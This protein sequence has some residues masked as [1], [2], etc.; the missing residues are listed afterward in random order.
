M[1]I[2]R[3]ASSDRLD[4]GRDG[5]CVSPAGNRGCAPSRGLRMTLPVPP[6][7]F[8][9]ID[10]PCGLSL[11]CNPLIS[12]AQHLWTTKQLELPGVEGWSRVAAA[13]QVTP[14]QIM[15]IRQVHGRHVHV[16][17]RDVRGDPIGRPEA[18]A[19]ISND[20]SRVLAIQVADCV[21]ILLADVRGGAAAAV[22]A[23]W[24]GTASGIVAATIE[25]LD[26]EF[27]SH[28]GDLIAAIGPSIGPCCYEVG[29]EL[30]PA[31]RR[32]G[33]SDADLDRWFAPAP[34]GRLWLDLWAATRDQL[35]AAGVLAARIFVAGLC[36]RSHAT[37]FASY[38]ADGE[39]AG[40]MAAL[41]RVPE[42]HTR[43]R[44]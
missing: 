7:A 11:R 15:R 17:R 25:A 5:A 10:E 26:R 28:P 30:P 8:R 43:G 34:S 40:R 42:P 27:G 9:W 41:I 35:M 6:A 31:F 20:P 32:G 38:R 36:S 4:F 33:A 3:D 2:K 13:M 16:W 22:H 39:R 29:D 37:V 44:A 14:E 21:P 1:E 19:Q 24:R 23:G 18:D 12:V